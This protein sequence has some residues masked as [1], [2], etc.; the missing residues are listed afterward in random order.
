MNY[1]DSATAMPTPDQQTTPGEVKE[2]A[3]RLSLRTNRPVEVRF[4][5]ENDQKRIGNAMGA[6]AVGHGIALVICLLVARAMADPATQASLL[7][8]LPEQIVWLA[9]PGPGGGG[10]GGNKSPEPP[11]KAEAPGKQEVTIPAIKTPVPEEVP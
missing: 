10:G 9:Q 1:R 5:F 11:R 3:G 4:L 2:Q 6:S 7:S 8:R